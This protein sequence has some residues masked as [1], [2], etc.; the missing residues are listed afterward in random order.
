MMVKK[1]EKQA[2]EGHNWHSEIILSTSLI[3]D[4]TQTYKKQKKK[5]K[6]KSNFKYITS[7]KKSV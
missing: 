7:R 1:K 2:I 4:E 6:K 5:K 3:N